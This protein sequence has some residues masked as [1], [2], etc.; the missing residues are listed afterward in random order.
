MTWPINPN[1]YDV[2]SPG[3]EDLFA[4]IIAKIVANTAG[5]SSL[6]NAS[7]V[8]PLANGSFEDDASGTVVPTGWLVTNSPGGS[9]SVT[10][11]DSDHGANSY[12]AVHPGGALQGGT[13]LDTEV[14]L[15]VSKGQAFELYFSL[16]ATSANVRTKVYVHWYDSGGSEIAGSPVNIF[17]Q[18]GSHPTSWKTFSVGVSPFMT[19]AAAANAKFMAFT[20][21]LGDPSLSTAASIFVDNIALTFRRQF[22]RYQIFTGSG[23]FTPPQGVTRIKAMMWGG[24][25]GSSGGGTGSIGGGGGYVEGFLDVHPGVDVTVTVGTAGAGFTTATAT[26]MTSD[27]VTLTAGAGSNFPTSGRGSASGGYLN[28]TGSGGPYSSRFPLGPVQM[29]YGRGQL[30]GAGGQAASAGAVII[31]Y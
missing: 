29:D 17:D 21:T 24:G 14:L 27:G 1:R 25:A 9:G 7:N 20:F 26:T 4:D 11:T 5:I 23:T 6:V 2:D 15:P 13:I 30:A 18:N 10:N 16:Y 19:P 12:K 8:P 31:F 3:S 28:L 22:S